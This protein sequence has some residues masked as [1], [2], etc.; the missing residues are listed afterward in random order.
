VLVK[1]RDDY[2]EVLNIADGFFNRPAVRVTNNQLLSHMVV[3]FS[4]PNERDLHDSFGDGDE[5]AEGVGAIKLGILQGAGSIPSPG[6]GGVHAASPRMLATV[7]RPLSFLL[8]LSFK[9]Q[10][11]HLAI[12]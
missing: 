10:A 8:F 6:S 7:L 9:N 1:S 4:V 12:A 2:G 3:V 5:Q 11:F